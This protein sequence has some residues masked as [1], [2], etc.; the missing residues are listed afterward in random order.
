MNIYLGENLKRLR[1]EKELT[2]EDVANIL[3]IS[4]QS[5]SKWERGES[6]PDIT[7]LPSLASFF[8]VSVDEL[9]GVDAAENEEKIKKYL[10][11]I[12]CLTD[13]QAALEKAKTALEEFPADFRLQGRYL[14]L[15]IAVKGSQK[16][17]M[18]ILSE[19]RGIFENIQRNCTSDNIRITAKKHMAQL[20]RT[21]SRVKNSGVTADDARA[22][23]ADMPRMRDS[24]DFLSTFMYSM[25]EK[26]QKTA[27]RNCFDE[28]IFLFNAAV[29]HY[30]F[31]DSFTAEFK[32]KAIKLLL[33]I[34]NTLYS[35]GNYGSNWRFVIDRYA[36]LGSIYYEL[37][38][39]NK[40]LEYFSKSA[41]LAKKFDSLPQ[42]SKRHALLFEGAQFDKNTLGSTFI[43]SS[44]L[45]N[46]LFDLYKLSDEF[47][48]SEEFIKIIYS[49]DIAAA[50]SFI[51][52]CKC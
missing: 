5:V 18:S 52:P 24:G 39:K 34:E 21:L 28:L 25:E 23:I 29:C 14:F 6:Y 20:Y 17:G 7:M 31:N 43:A 37:G 15:L 38:N 48:N 9:L 30:C 10:Y 13:K 16:E 19:A 50:K 44:A 8:K 3:G 45:K 33:D 49:L 22:I 12:D 26:D 2:Q 47:L 41:E 11:K 35:D 40:A 32:E 46:R 42:I 51:F 27:C 4:F 1:K 36:D